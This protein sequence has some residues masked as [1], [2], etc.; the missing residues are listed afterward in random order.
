MI[1][2]LFLNVI[3]YAVYPLVFLIAQLSDV[4]LTSAIG[5]A[6]TTASGY[7]A[8]LNVFIPVATILSILQA[9]IVYELAYF[10][11]KLIYWII[12]RIPTQS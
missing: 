5:T 1:V 3:Y 10:T 2:T 11:F 12:K 6:V 8:G 9:F 7:L 4:S